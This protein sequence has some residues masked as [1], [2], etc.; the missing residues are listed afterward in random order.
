M[1]GGVHVSQ[2]RISAHGRKKIE[3]MR[4][5]MLFC[6]S[7]TPSASEEK[8]SWGSTLKRRDEH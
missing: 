4:L 2:L 5:H 3:M 7:T 6:S 8:N 1:K